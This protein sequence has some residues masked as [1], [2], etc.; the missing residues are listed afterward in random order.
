MNEQRFCISCDK[1]LEK[2]PHGSDFTGQDVIPSIYGAVIFRGTGNY[3][4]TVYDPMDG[5]H[6]LEVYLCDECILKKAEKIFH[7]T[8]ERKREEVTLV[9]NFND[10]RE[11]ETKQHEYIEQYSDMEKKLHTLATFNGLKL[12]KP[13]RERSGELDDTQA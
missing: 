1:T 11:R 5:G 9:Q 12:Q 4:S 2:D 3:G 10:Y 8:S 13:K 6:F 7:I